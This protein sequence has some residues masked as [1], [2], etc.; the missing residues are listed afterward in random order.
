M[1]ELRNKIEKEGDE[2]VTNYVKANGTG[3][4][5]LGELG[6]NKPSWADGI[7]IADQ[8]GGSGYTIEHSDTPNEKYY[9]DFDNEYVDF[10]VYTRKDSETKERIDA[11]DDLEYYIRLLAELVD[12]AKKEF[13]QSHSN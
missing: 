12:D 3:S 2:G 9:V 7:F 10:G 1:V 11:E 6:R 4:Q 5:I 13:G 8:Y